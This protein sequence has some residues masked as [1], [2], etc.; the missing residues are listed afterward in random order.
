MS[1]QNCRVVLVRPQ[2]AGNLGATAR[3]MRNMGLSDL[4]LVSPVAAPTD[5]E[6]RQRSTHGEEILDRCRIVTD[7]GEAV[8]RMQ[9]AMRA[10]YEAGWLRLGWPEWAGGGRSDDSPDS[11]PRGAGRAQ[12]RNAGSATRGRSCDTR[13]SSTS[14]GG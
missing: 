3:V 11:G 5:R 8:A 12:R 1:L 9:P 6:A 2:V 10:L 13:G 4:V 7:L 14:R